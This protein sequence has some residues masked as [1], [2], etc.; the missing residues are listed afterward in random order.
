MEPNTCVNCAVPLSISLAHSAW[1]HHKWGLSSSKLFWE[2]AKEAKECGKF[3]FQIDFPLWMKNGQSMSLINRFT[4]S[5]KSYEQ[6]FLQIKGVGSQSDYI[7]IIMCFRFY[8][9]IDGTFVP[10]R[11]WRRSLEWNLL[12]WCNNLSRLFHE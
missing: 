1:K 3:I 12:K 2:K 8:T 5:R 10:L 11:I 9:A 4:D 7:N 6:H